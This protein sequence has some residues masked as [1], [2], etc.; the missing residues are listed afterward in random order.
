MNVGDTVSLKAGGPP[1]VIARVDKV[2][3]GKQRIACVWFYKGK[4][5]VDTFDPALLQ[6]T[7]LELKEGN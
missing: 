2:P 4:K 1:M 5:T 3:P 7:S 6:S